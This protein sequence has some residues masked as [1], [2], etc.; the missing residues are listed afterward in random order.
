[1]KFQDFNID[2]KWRTAVADLDLC[3]T[4]KTDNNG[5]LLPNAQRKTILVQMDNYGAYELA[6]EILKGLNIKDTRGSK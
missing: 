2:V 5:N 3:L 4:K 1:M 6:M